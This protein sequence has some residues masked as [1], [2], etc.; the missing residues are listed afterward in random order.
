[1]E[2]IA[3][4]RLKFFL[5]MMAVLL[6]IVGIIAISIFFVAVRGAEQTLVPEVRG[7]ELTEALLELQVKELYPRIQLRYSQSSRDRGQIL[8]QDPRAGTI[9]KAGRQIRLVVSQGVMI[10]RV[11]NYV[12]RNI[13]DVRMDLQTIVASAG[14]NP[15]LSLKEPLMYDFSPEAPGTILRQKPEPGTDISG[16]MS[17]EFVI[18]QGQ[19]HALLT[20]PQLVGLSLSSVLEQIGRMGIVFEFSLREIRDGE[21]GETVV[22]QTPPAGTSVTSNVVVDLVVN[23]PA[24][25]KGG[26]VF[27]LFTYTMP[28]NP[29]PLPVRLEAI[30]PSGERLRLIG[31]E[32]PGGKFT[33]PYRLPVESVLILSMM[34]R[35][36]YRE[37]VR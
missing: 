29:Y 24:Q 34:N 32:Y 10:N 23:T 14:N 17:L 1:M 16:P 31:V 19:E 26:E 22:Y 5:S 12:G 21:K 15:L 4:K 28:Q 30:L 25:L 8:E 11:E 20:V 33:V 37:T 13:D 7:K 27:K 2:E 18:S 9:V 35:E 36:I 6:V 3:A